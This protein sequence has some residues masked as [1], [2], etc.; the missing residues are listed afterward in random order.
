[1]QL[2]LKA[3]KIWFATEPVDFR[4]GI[5]GLSTMVVSQLASQIQAGIYVF[6]NR[7]KNKL[8]LLA[9]HRN[10]MMLIYKCL[11]KK[12]FTISHTESALYEMDEKQLSWLLAGLDWVEM[13]VSEG[14]VFDDYF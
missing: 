12:K 10:G 5:N 14:L 3:S 1:M 2:H 13:S 4:R 11:D 7:A 9:Y 6:Y 8:K